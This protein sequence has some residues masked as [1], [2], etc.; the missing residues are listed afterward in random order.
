MILSLSRSNWRMASL[1][2]ILRG[3][4]QS[5]HVPALAQGR[6]NP[7]LFAWMGATYSLIF[8]T[9]SSTVSTI[10]FLPAITSTLRGPKNRAATL[11]STP[12]RAM[13]SPNLVMALA[14]VR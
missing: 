3:S 7:L 14:L 4:L 5:T 13:I 12:S 10:L 6:F 11:S 9:P 2:H 8:L 1:L